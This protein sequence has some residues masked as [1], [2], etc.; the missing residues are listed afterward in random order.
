MKRQFRLHLQQSSRR[1]RTPLSGI[2][3]ASL[4]LVG[5]DQAKDNKPL[6]SVPAPRTQSLSTSINEQ[7]SQSA[8]DAFTHADQ[9]ADQLVDDIHQFLDSP[10][11]TTL[12]QVRNR[13]R[14]AYTAFLQARFYGFL[15]IN[16]PPEW[17]KQQIGNRVTMALL[18]TWPIEGGYIDYLADYPYSGIVNDL[19][20]ELTADNLIAQHGL[21]DVSSASLGF[22]PLEFLLWG[23][24]GQ[25]SASD[26]LP[27]ANTVAL[28]APTTAK[29]TAANSDPDDSN[30]NQEEGE[31]GGDDTSSWDDRPVM[32]QNNTRRRD[33]LNLVSAQI[34]DNVHRLE[35]RWEPGNGYYA[36]LIGRSKP[37][38][39]L[40]AGL[41]A[42][43]RLLNDELINKRLVLASSEFSQ[44]SR[45]DL[46]ALV[47]GLESWINSG[48]LRE[49][50]GDTSSLQRD[51]QE[52]FRD[53]Y[54]SLEQAGSSAH[55]G[56]EDSFSDEENQSGQQITPIKSAR[57]L[58]ALLRRTASQ[59]GVSLTV[60]G[61]A[62]HG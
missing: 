43:Q 19:T 50:P 8:F 15:P 22:H 58:L 24:N 42:G 57:H 36:T 14:Q 10:N 62:T 6:E 47:E 28:L 61:S 53:Y 49:L 23:E 37:G 26:Y 16:D 17:Q 59:A 20:L 33:Y 34:Q 5:C 32:V 12:E 38:Q 29:P 51:W 52:G 9:L 13:W 35:R 21:S 44:T 39:A 55:P 11:A 46:K 25:R 2:A 3:L 31:G 60:S 7:L 30:T 40:S 45:D 41:I 1:L 54:S 27:N 18:D 4:L 56:D 48:I